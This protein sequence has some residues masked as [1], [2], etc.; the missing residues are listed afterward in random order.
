M[1]RGVAYEGPV[2]FSLRSFSDR[3]D[4][5]ATSGRNKK[6]KGIH[7]LP[8]LKEAAG[9]HSW[10]EGCVV[11]ACRYHETDPANQWETEGWMDGKQELLHRKKVMLASFSLS[12]MRH[13]TTVS[14]G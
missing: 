14:H 4:R 13:W 10:G 6:L 5:E 12:A 11:L 7:I 3:L 8:E 9:W 2:A 1:A